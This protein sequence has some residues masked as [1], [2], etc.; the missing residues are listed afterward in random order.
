MH[1]FQV[2]RLVARSTVEE[3]ILRRANRKLELTR[4]VIDAGQYGGERYAQIVATLLILY[5]R[6]HPRI[7]IIIC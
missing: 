4:A 7:Q 5:S 3:V 1:I 2:I 6:L